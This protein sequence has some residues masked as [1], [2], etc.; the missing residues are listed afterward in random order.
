MRQTD[1]QMKIRLSPELKENIAQSARDNMR[2]LNAEIVSRLQLS[3]EIEQGKI[4]NNFVNNTI[5]KI[6]EKV[7]RRIVLEELN[8][9]E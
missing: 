7:A 1:P 6:A 5:E 3:Y 9:P 2:T 8:K 4:S